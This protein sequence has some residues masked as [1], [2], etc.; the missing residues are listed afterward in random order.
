[1]ENS[2]VDE[3]LTVLSKTLLKLRTVEEI[4]L[5]LQDLLTRGEQE[6]I[7]QRLNIAD[8]LNEGIPYSQIQRETGASSATVAKVSDN[9]KYGKDGFKLALD[10]LSKSR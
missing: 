10:R 4:K 6:F 9:L 7:A 8:M 3:K 2:L 1:M 5:F